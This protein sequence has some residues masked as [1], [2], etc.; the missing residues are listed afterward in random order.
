MIAALVGL[1]IVLAANLPTARAD[2]L[3]WDTNA[4]APGPQGGNGA[5]NTSGSNAVWWNS[6]SGTDIP[7]DNLHSAIFGNNAGMVNVGT[8][9]ATGLEFDASGYTLSG[10]TITLESPASIIVNQTATIESNV[11]GSV[12]NLSTADGATFFNAPAN[13]NALNVTG[14]VVN[15]GEI[16]TAD[17]DAIYFQGA[18][19]D[20]SSGTL[21]NEDAG[22]STRGS[23]H[24]NTPANFANRGFHFANGLT[25][26]VYSSITSLPYNSSL[27]S[28]MI[29]V[30]GAVNGGTTTPTR[31]NFHGTW[32]GEGGLNSVYNELMLENQS[33][34]YVSAGAAFD[35]VLDD[36]VDQW[37]RQE[38]VGGDG[39]GNV[40]E[41]DPGF[42]AVQ[43]HSV[44]DPYH[45]N[46]DIL[47]SIQMTGGATLITHSTQ[48]L[49]VYRRYLIGDSSPNNINGHVSF[50]YDLNG[51]PKWE[52]ESQPQTYSG[53]I[54]SYVNSTIQTD[55]D[56]TSTGVDHYDSAEN[57]NA[58]NGFRIFAPSDTALKF[59]TVTKTG[60]GKLNLNGDQAYAPGSVLQINGGV[61]DFNSDPG[62]PTVH[63]T[64]NTHP[65]G[66]TLTVNVAAGAEALFAAPRNHVADLN[67]SDGQA[68]I[69]QGSSDIL[70]TAGLGISGM[71]KLDIGEGGLDVQEGNL[72]QIM[73]W[74]NSGRD[75][76]DWLGDG[77]VSSY[78]AEYGGELIVLPG[79]ANL[80]NTIFAGLPV[81]STDVVVVYVPEPE[82][83]AWLLGASTLMFLRPR[84][85]L[86]NKGDLCF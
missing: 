52:V 68:D 31:V 50:Y 59:C 42:V 55:T 23:A 22:L 64:D 53:A 40:F 79:S 1:A 47:G 77:I 10:G 8:V 74:V 71:G 18:Y 15:N 35:E 29:I 30:S 56:L 67:I 81:A 72:S 80:S 66:Q 27:P 17:G 85:L 25:N 3:Y 76:G 51:S 41:L 82:S 86:C 57:Y 48:S 46:R 6:L 9:T 63:L 36:N 5:W 20:S 75:G 2:D 7:W 78:A 24:L 4:S 14:A 83:G 12:G 38:W 28:P 37:A 26:N 21:L 44:N 11:S 61:V 73:A 58:L 60:L 32:H 69:A 84:K 16:D 34:F 33:T 54:W 65:G 13:K 62:D 43:D 45:Q 39:S 49:P 70:F 19:S